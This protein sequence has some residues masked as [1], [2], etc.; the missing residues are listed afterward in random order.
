[1]S[2]KSGITNAFFPNYK[3]YICDSLPLEKAST[4]HKVIMLNKSV[5]NKHQNNFYNIIFLE[6]CPYR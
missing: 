3:I 1:M 2:Q 6:K 4:L 5:F